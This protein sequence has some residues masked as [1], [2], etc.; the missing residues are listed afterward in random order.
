MKA[1]KFI[2]MLMICGLI[3]GTAGIVNANVREVAPYNATVPVVAD[4][5]TSPLTKVNTS[6]AVNNVS[7]I[8]RDRALVSWIEDEGGANIT[9]K[10]T[11]SAT[12]RYIMNYSSANYYVNKKVKLNLST[13]LNQWTTTSTTGTW[14]PDEQ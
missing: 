11:Y 10:V 1:R 3:V 12:G 9:N 6:S 2:S 7:T 14:S 4:F 8:E 5:E 13:P